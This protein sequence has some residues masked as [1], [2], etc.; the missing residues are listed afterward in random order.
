MKY[1]SVSVIQSK[2]GCKIITNG[3]GSFRAI[4]IFDY[5][6]QAYHYAMG[7][8]DEV[9]VHN[10]NGTIKFVTNRKPKQ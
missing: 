10:E 7:I 8:S 1:N 4:K 3:L 9:F 2:K 5:P 6:E